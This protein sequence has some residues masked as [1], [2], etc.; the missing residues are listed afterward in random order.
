MTIKQ[1][2][3]PQRQ[4][5]VRADGGA[6]ARVVRE[7]FPKWSPPYNADCM[8]CGHTWITKAV[9]SKNIRCGKCGARNAFMLENPDMVIAVV[10]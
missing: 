2:A 10:R 1:D 7:L 9:A 5:A 8:T 6:A 4:L 3:D